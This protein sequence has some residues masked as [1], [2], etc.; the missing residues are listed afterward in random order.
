MLFADKL[1]FISEKEGGEA[2]YDFT[3]HRD[4]T[5]MISDFNYIIMT[6]YKCTCRYTRKYTSKCTCTCTMSCAFST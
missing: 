2:S 1:G 6:L 3:Y 4:D 5:E